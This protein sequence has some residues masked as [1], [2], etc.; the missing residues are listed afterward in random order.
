MNEK[1]L[2]KVD[3]ELATTL[4]VAPTKFDKYI[5]LLKNE[6]GYNLTKSDLATILNKSIQTLDRRIASGS[7]IPNYIRSGNG[8]NAS[9]IFPIIEV[10]EFL[11][12]TTKTLNEEYLDE[13]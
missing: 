2:S 6:F 1:N 11:C 12:N 4:S 8:K 3:L 9:Y 5:V 13:R 7:H 10:A